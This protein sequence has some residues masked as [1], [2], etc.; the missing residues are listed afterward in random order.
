MNKKEFDFT[1]EEQENML[2]TAELILQLEK[3]GW[4]NK[5]ELRRINNMGAVCISMPFNT[6]EEKMK[7]I[8]LFQ[9]ELKNKKVDIQINNKYKFVWCQY[10]E[11]QK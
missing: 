5:K 4:C 2:E 9:L 6:L 7:I 1:Q 8:S 11:I 3:D 10:T